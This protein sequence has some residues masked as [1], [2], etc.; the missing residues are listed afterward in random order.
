M[1]N[2]TFLARTMVYLAVLGLFL[3]MPFMIKRYYLTVLGTG[4][5]YVLL[6]LSLNII[7]GFAGRISICQGAFYGIGAYACGLLVVKSSIAFWP[8]LVLGTMLTGFMAFLVGIPFVRAKGPY[9]AIGTLCFGAIVSLVLLNWVSLT[10]GISLRGI[11]GPQGFGFIDF[12]T[13]NTYYYLLLIMVVI[14]IFINHKLLNSRTG[15]ALIAIREDETLAEC[16]AVNTT[17]YKLFAFTCAGLLAGLT[18]GLYAGYMGTIDPGI[19]GI[20]NSFIILI[21]LVAGGSGTIS[22][23]IIGP[24]LLWVLPELLMFADEFRVL[25]YGI[26]LLLIIIF[27]PKGIAG[28]LGALS[29]TIAKWLP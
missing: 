25:I 10:G 11:K 14:Y 19:A 3:A 28:Q 22:G 23:A 2:G 7:T 4:L 6:V 5:F 17:G 9:F 16:I 29:P 20:G 15:R 26:I 18:G 21:M 24:L 13:M 27:M 8:A 1:K 12:A